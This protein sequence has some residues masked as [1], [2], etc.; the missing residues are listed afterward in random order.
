MQA[1]RILGAGQDYETAAR[2]FQQ[3]HAARPGSIGNGAVRVAIDLNRP[4]VAIEV[5]QYILDRNR[6]EMIPYIN[7]ADAYF[8]NREFERV[9]EVFESARELNLAT[10]RNI[11]STY[12]LALLF[13]GKFEAA[14][15]VFDE[16]GPGV[17]FERRRLFGRAITLHRL[18]REQEFAAALAAIE[19]NLAS[20]GAVERAIVLAN[21][22]DPDTAFELFNSASAL[23]PADLDGPMLDAM[24]NHAGW[25][26]LA[27]KAGIWPEDPRDSIEFEID[28]PE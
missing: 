11:R 10:S 16:I 7:L 14:L 2:Y 28:L 13:N 24:R 17:I 5:A 25:P 3:A 1:R 12:G 6:L 9:E 23:S 20:G 18:G 22:G 21:T 19:N 27:E 15:S 8:R 26:V 4:E